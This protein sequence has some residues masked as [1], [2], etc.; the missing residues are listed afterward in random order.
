MR[1][2]APFAR[3]FQSCHQLG[4]P[5]RRALSRPSSQYLCLEYPRPNQGRGIYGGPKQ[6]TNLYSMLSRPCWSVRSLLPDAKTAP[7]TLITVDQLRHFLQ[8]S[9]L[10]IPQT[11]KARS[12]MMDVLLS[13]LHFVRDI[14]SVDTS[15][16]EP[17][18]SIRDETEEGLKEQTIGVEQL[19]AALCQESP[20]GHCK[21][22]RRKKD[23][24]DGRSTADWDVLKTASRK[25][26]RYFVVRSG[27]N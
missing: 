27:K 6:T 8:L 18:R 7:D 19:R 14:Q 22:P 20:F 5:Q 26:G 25:A 24:P 10:P 16:V 17:L 11:P 21:R 4:Q 12:Q 15:G 23:E 9:A 13:Q 2:R 3:P 1:C